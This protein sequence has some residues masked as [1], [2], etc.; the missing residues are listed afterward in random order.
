MARSKSEQRLS[1]SGL[2]LQELRTG[3]IGDTQQSMKVFEESIRQNPRLGAAHLI[4]AVGQIHVESSNLGQP[5]LRHD[6]D[7]RDCLDAG[8]P[9]SDRGGFRSASGFRAL[10]TGGWAELFG[11]PNDFGRPPA[12]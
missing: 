4:P 10:L 5:L 12:R 7:V 2:Q 1:R 6:G 11:Y 3:Q 8:E 9:S